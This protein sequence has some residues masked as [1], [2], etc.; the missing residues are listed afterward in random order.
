MCGGRQQGQITPEIR[1]APQDTTSNYKNVKRNDHQPQWP[2]TGWWN[3]LV[4]TERCELRCDSTHYTYWRHLSWGWKGS[5][6]STCGDGRR[7]QA[8]DCEN[9]KK[10]LQTQRKHNESWEGSTENFKEQHWPHY[11]TA[12]QG[13]ATVILNT[14]DYKQK[15]TSLLEDPSYRRLTRDPTDST[16]WKTT[17]LFKKSTLTEDI[18]KQLRLAG[19]RPPRRYIK[20]RRRGITQKK[21][22]NIQNMVKVWN[23]DINTVTCTQVM[24]RNAWKSSSKGSKSVWF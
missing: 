18:G 5:T 17:L 8:R 9:Y 20:F 14:V 13:N 7:N 3:V 21:A 15:I 22:Y 2:A 6:I 23:Q 16:E 10:L 4:T 11:P 19:S 24:Y 12:R 1:T